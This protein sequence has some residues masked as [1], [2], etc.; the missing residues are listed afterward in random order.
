MRLDLPPLSPLFPI[1]LPLILVIRIQYIYIYIYTYIYTAMGDYHDV[2]AKPIR[3]VAVI[4]AGASGLV[5]A[6]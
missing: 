5:A 2:P 6:K 3:R 4:G 1:T